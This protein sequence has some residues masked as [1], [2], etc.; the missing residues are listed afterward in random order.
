VLR[1]IVKKIP[2]L[3]M[4]YRKF[5]PRSSGK[6]ESSQLKEGPLFLSLGCY[7]EKPVRELDIGSELSVKVFRKKI[8]GKRRDTHGRRGK[9]MK[10]KE[11]EGAN[12]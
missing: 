12:Q 1:G 8:K 6:V 11:N 7:L 2:G 5:S 3:D 9:R 4:G 10:T